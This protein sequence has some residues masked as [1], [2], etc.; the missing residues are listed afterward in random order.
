MSPRK[1]ALIGRQLSQRPIDEAI[2]QMQFSEKRSSR[3]LANAMIQG[4]NS[5]V[6]LGMQKDKLYLR[7]SR[8]RPHPSLQ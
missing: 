2:L 7:E 8:R 4:R 3:R 1:L 5:A 6:Q